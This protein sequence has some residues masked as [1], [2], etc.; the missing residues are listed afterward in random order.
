MKNK[1]PETPFKPAVI[2]A[3][4]IAAVEIVILELVAMEKE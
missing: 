1:Q 2:A 3:V 4:E